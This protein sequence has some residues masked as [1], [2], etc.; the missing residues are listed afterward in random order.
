[1]NRSRSFRRMVPWGFGLI[2]VLI[3]L[4]ILGAGL[5]A[6]VRMQTTV[7]AASSLSKQRTEATALCQKKVEELRSFVSLDKYDAYFAS[8]ATVGP[9]NDPAVQGETALFAIRYTLIDQRTDPLTGRYADISVT[10][11]WTDSQN[12]AHAVD[13]RSSIARVSPVDTAYLTQ[14]ASAPPPP[15]CA[16]D[17]DERNWTVSGATCAGLITT[18]GDVGS[19]VTV[20]ATTNSGTNQYVCTFNGTWGEVTSYPRTCRNICPSSVRSWYGTN[21]ETCVSSAPIEAKSAGGASTV[22]DSVPNVTGSATFSCTATG[23]WQLTSSNCTATCPL[24]QLEWGSDA[25]VNRACAAE[26]GPTNAPLTDTELAPTHTTQNPRRATYQ[27]TVAGAW[28]LTSSDCNLEV[29]RTC[30]AQ[31]V[32]WGTGSNRCEGTLPSSNPSST[33]IAVIDPLNGST[34]TAYYQCQ[35]AGTWQVQSNPAATCRNNCTMRIQGSKPGGQL[36]IQVKVTGAADASYLT[37]CADSS[38]NFNCSGIPIETGVS[39]TVRASK[40]SSGTITGKTATIAAASCGGN[41]TGLSLN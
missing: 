27:C 33:T 35:T 14:V 15:S 17:P 31:A 24:T 36:D 1:M 5:L 28:M 38:K 19:L 16:A 3:A 9:L 29:F 26:F 4:V 21:G 10:C 39:Y 7:F 2:E 37:V 6:V 12:A 25:D 30:P 22:T 11:S 41:F 18:P 8:G 13:L 34:G 32:T 40:K 20:A 23:D